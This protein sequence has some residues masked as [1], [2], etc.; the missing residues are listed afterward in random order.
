MYLLASLA[1]PSVVSNLI[2]FPYLTRAAPQ[3]ILLGWHQQQ[4]QLMKGTH[5]EVAVHRETIGIE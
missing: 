4:A 1:Y 5:R 3:G 2:S